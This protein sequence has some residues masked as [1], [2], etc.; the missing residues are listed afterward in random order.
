MATLKDVQLKIAAVKKTKQIT[1]AMNMVAASKLRG[2]QNKMEGFRPYASKF[3]EVLGSLAENAGEEASPLL[4]PREEVK[5]IGVVLCTSDRGLCGGFNANLINRAES[6]FKEKAEHDIDVAYTNFGKKGR[7]WARNN[8]KAIADVYLG[9]VGGKFDFSVAVN[10]G[11][12]LIGSFL[13]GEYDE[14]YLIYSEFVSMA[15]QVPVI[16]Q[17][18]PIPPIETA[19]I[20]EADEEPSYI[21]EHICEPSPAEL[22]GDMLPK[23]VFV[24]LYSALLETSTSEHAARMTAMD[25]ATKACNDM[26]ENLTLAYNKA[27]QAAITSDLMDIVGGAE[28]LKG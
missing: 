24:Q 9:V 3:S 6:F 7:D 15:R 8:K 22:L 20:E 1:K 18:L 5:K 4:I 16:K 25:N 10:A 2:A 27:R 23:N 19:D 21:A 14:V 12:K 17:L 28:A 13:D 11:R 26:I